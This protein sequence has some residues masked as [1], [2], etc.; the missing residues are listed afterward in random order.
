MKRCAATDPREQ[1]LKQLVRFASGV[2]DAAHEALRCHRADADAET[3]EKAVELCVRR[4]ERLSRD[5]LAH[6]SRLPR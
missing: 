6:V 1:H 5:I 2:E 3:R 4:C